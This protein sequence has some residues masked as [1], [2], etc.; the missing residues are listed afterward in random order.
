MTNPT[1]LEVLNAIKLLA[2]FMPEEEDISWLGSGFMLVVSDHLVIKNEPL[3]EE[4]KLK[5]DDKTVMIFE[6]CTFE[7]GATAALNLVELHMDDIERLHSSHKLKRNQ[8][9]EFDPAM[10][11]SL[12]NGVDQ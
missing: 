11:N 7:M 10:I 8:M 6:K 3:L 2:E 12:I 4:F 9:I 1:K 5:K